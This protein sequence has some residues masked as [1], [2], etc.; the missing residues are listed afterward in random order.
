MKREVLVKLHKDFESIVKT[1]FQSGLEFWCARELQELLQYS[2]WQNFNKV[3]EKAKT[4]CATAGYDISNHFIDTDKMVS[5]GSG[6]QR[7]IA[8]ILLT[9]YACYLIAQNADP[10]KEP[11]AFAQTYFAVQ[12]RKQ[13]VIERRLAERDRLTARKKLSDSE[14]QLSGVVYERLGKEA[15]FAKLRS[16]GDEALFGGISTQGMKIRLRVPKN[17]AL[18]DF[19][20]SITIKAKDFANEITTFNIKRDELTGETAIDAEHVKNNRDVRKL[21]TDRG[22]QPERLPAAEDIRA[23]QRRVASDEKKIPPKPRAR[24]NRK[25]DNPG[26]SDPDSSD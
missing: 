4:A 16:R 22:I 8:D 7:P 1:D 10:S 6:G 3:I 17:R 20:P 18:A 14:K 13:E 9:R 12:T 24:M 19:L 2:N 23:V 15:D 11:I 26:P 25:P 21:L 5:I